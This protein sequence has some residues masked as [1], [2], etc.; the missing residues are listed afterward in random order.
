MTKIH[1]ANSINVYDIIN[2]PSAETP[3]IGD[4]VY[5]EVSEKFS[6]L[7]KTNSSDKLIINLA[8]INSLT[9]AFLNNAIGKL[10]FNYEPSKIIKSLKVEGIEN[11][12]IYD[13]VMFSLS[14]AIA[15]TK[16]NNI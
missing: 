14:N 16:K 9:S 7:I 11:K 10:F 8:K 13:A 5:N 4:K 3:E 12:T 1:Y 2:S 15:L 6:N